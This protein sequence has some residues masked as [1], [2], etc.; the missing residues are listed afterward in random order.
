MGFY[1]QL[2][3]DLKRTQ[4]RM[5]KVEPRKGS[6]NG[7]AAVAPPGRGAPNGTNGVSTQSYRSRGLSS[8]R[9]RSFA[10]TSYRV[11]GMVPP[12]RQPKSQACWATVTTMLYGWRE[13]QS[14]PIETVLGQIGS[15]WLAKFQ[16]NEPLMSGETAAFGAASGLQSEP[17]M[18]YSVDGWMQMLRVYGPLWV[19]TS[20]IPGH[21]FSMHA[22]VMVGMTTDGTPGGTT[23]QIVD[24]GSGSE[25]AESLH[26]FWR[27]FEAEP[28]TPGGPLVIQVLHWPTGT[29]PA[30]QSRFMHGLSRNGSA[31]RAAFPRAFDDV[32]LPAPLAWG[33]KV[34]QAFRDK[35]R[36]IASNLGCDPDFL[37]AAMAFET[38]ESFSPSIKNGAGSGATGLIQF[39]PTTAQR[40]GTTVAD[41]AKMSA[42]DQ[43]DY[44]EKYFVPFKGRLASLEDVYMAILWPAAV[45]KPNTYVLFS[46]STRPRA[47][48][49][50][51]GLDLNRDGDI[52]R[53]EAASLVQS[54]LTRG[55]SSG[56]AM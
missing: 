12:I 1:Q 11:P 40:L 39:M 54:K 34:S 43:L 55:R 32:A 23:V 16:N 29:Q 6:A 10:T 47:Y 36:Q 14:I 49:Q 5:L 30:A 50:N 21:P 18:S 28:S 44:V 3:E 52:T 42:E 22:R 26:D 31:V 38:G 19:T 8:T 27:K 35:V 24:P 7:R 41:L 17:P 33:A 46:R 2:Q 9:V 45:G 15:K 48:S 20:E 56:N 4:Q 13:A 51:Q 37:M 53:Q 25:Y